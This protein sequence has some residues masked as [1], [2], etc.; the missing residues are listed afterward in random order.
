MACGQAVYA[1]PML[2]LLAPE[3]EQINQGVA[4]I[5]NANQGNTLVFCALGYSRSAVLV[6]ASLLAEKRRQILNKL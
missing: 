3:V 4:A 1:V 5:K 6:I 2:D